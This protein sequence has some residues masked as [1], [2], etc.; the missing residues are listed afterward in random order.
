MMK[1]M[2]AYRSILR[3]PDVKK[4]KK[5]V[6]RIITLVRVNASIVLMITVD[7]RSEG[8]PDGLSYSNLYQSSSQL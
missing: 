7:H 1:E 6:Y 3:R 2:S 5:V 8:M 4:M